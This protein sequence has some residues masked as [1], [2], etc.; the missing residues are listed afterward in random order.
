MISL[1]IIIKDLAVKIDV[2]I[3]EV[4]NKNILFVNF[5]IRVKS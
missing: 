1:A 5:N 2:F 4:K 3:H